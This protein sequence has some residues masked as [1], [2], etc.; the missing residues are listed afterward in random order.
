MSK[1]KSTCLGLCEVAKIVHDS[2]G[3]VTIEQIIDMTDGHRRSVRRVLSA[4]TSF[5]LVSVAG[6]RP[7]LFSWVHRNV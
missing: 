5:G 1:R 2:P 4:L 3:A 7:L 6:T